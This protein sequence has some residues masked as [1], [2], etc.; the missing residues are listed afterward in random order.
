MLKFKDDDAEA[1]MVKLLKE[2]VTQRKSGHYSL[3]RYRF[4]PRWKSQVK[5]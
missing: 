1:V 2:E 5:K 4:Q 3:N